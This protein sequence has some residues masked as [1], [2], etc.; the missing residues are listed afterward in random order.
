M[1][2]T[3][4]ERAALSQA[5]RIDALCAV[6]AELSRLH[7]VKLALVAELEAVGRAELLAEAA[8]HGVPVRAGE[9]AVIED[10]GWMREEIACALRLSPR[11]AG[12]L[13]AL[14]QRAAGP[15]APAR[16]ALQRGELSLAHLRRLDEDTFPLGEPQTAAV[17]KR[18]LP[19]CGEI[20]AAAFSRRIRRAVLACD[21]RAAEEKHRDGLA[22][23][24]VAIRDE[25]AG[26]MSLWAL[27]PAEACLAIFNALTHAAH[28]TPLPEPE[29]EIA[30]DERTADQRRADML[31]ELITGAT[32]TTGDATAGTD[33][34]AAGPALTIRGL[35]PAVQVTIPL[36]AL[37]GLSEA[38]GVLDGYGPITAEAAR[39]IAADPTGTLRR[40]ITDQIGTLLEVGRRAY[41]PPT[42]LARHI[43]ARDITC[44][45]PG[46]QRRA[47]GCDLDHCQ[48]WADLG[49][50][51]EANLHALCARHHHLKH[52]TAWTVER[53]EDGTTI[54]T[55]PT[56]HTYAR[57]PET[58]PTADIATAASTTDPDPP[59]F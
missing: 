19:G 16:A 28:T 4:E 9:L 44:C 18:V 23:R 43:V 59:P 30:K 8:A 5:Q 24:R 39:R 2:D 42:A 45:F 34:E 54:W 10:K 15:L 25:G 33:R 26:M 11:G 56:G 46:C 49:P 48:D 29:C 58:H 37:L 32:V 6:E 36:A 14:A 41:R 1:F 47:V 27:L 50:T 22:E 51:T 31:V 57:L 7:A 40:L 20:T 13:L 35:R 52:D 53:T 17:L 38:P 21:T 3:A 12:N 55:A